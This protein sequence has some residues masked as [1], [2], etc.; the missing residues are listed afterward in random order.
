VPGH[1]GIIGNEEDDKL[2]RQA[3]AIPLPGPEPALGIPKCSAREAI[4]TWTENQHH[5]AWRDL[6]GHRQGKLFIG[7]S[8]KKRADVLLKL[9]RHKLKMVVAI[10]TGHDPLKR[11]LNIMGLFKGDP[12]CRFCRKE[13]ETVQHIICCCEALARQRYNVFGDPFVEPKDISTGSV[14]DLCLF[15]RGTGLL[16]LC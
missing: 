15:I 12:T 8:C 7:R 14:R 4:R 10:L 3:S 5:S 1:C 13:T 9:S 6:P 16:N 2:A 11:H